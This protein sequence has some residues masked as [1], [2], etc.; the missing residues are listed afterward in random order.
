MPILTVPDGPA[1]LMPTTRQ[2]RDDLDDAIDDLDF[3]DLWRGP[4]TIAQA[5]VVR[6]DIQ[7]PWT[8]GPGQNIQ[9]QVGRNS[10]AAIRVG[11]TLAAAVGAANQAAVV[12][13]VGN[14]LRQ[15]MGGGVW[16]EVTGTQP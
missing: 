2:I 1:V 13:A 16:V 5:G 11:V 4:G 3:A 15:S 8:A 12:T 9:A 14:A 10:I 6:I 7:G